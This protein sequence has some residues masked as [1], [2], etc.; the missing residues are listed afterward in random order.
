MN[1]QGVEKSSNDFSPESQASQKH[2]LMA[3]CQVYAGPGSR[4]DGCPDYLVVLDLLDLR[5]SEIDVNTTLEEASVMDISL[6]NSS[7]SSQARPI[8]HN[9]NS[10]PHAIR[11]IPYSPDIFSC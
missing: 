5:T 6:S 3:I 8:P 11:F 10:R 1:A 9:H 4:S 7:L 2:K